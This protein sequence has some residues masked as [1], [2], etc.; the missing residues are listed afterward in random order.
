MEESKGISSLL[1]LPTLLLLV[2][3][4]GGLAWKNSLLTSPRHGGQSRSDQNGENEQHIE[5]RL[6]QDPL[7]VLSQS[8]VGQK[9]T[10]ALAASISKP[11]E[12][13]YET[14]DLFKERLKDR[15]ARYASQEGGE[16]P[17]VQ[18]LLAMVPSGLYAEDVESRL[19]IRE[20]VVSAL[21]VSGYRP[22]D[23]EHLGALE[24]P[25]SDNGTWVA[26]VAPADNK[27]I[28]ATEIAIPRDGKKIYLPLEWFRMRL[29]TTADHE[30]PDHALVLWLPDDLFQK[31]PWP[32]WRKLWSSCA[33]RYRQPARIHSTSGC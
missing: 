30:S 12:S 1:S 17:G 7:A 31:N 22:E 24:L 13:W 32:T 29:H 28:E 23:E 14:V 25:W 4:T 6:W 20:A 3:L 10:T 5:A 18:V 21:S 11:A 26:A 19:R 16:K 27:A 8:S 9:P 33:L 15:L 2:A